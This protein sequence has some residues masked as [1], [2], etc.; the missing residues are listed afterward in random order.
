LS[1]GLR[2]DLFVQSV[3]CIDLDDLRAKGIAGLA[4]DL[5]NTLVPWNTAHLTQDVV[6]W[7]AGMHAAGVRGCIVSNAGGRRVLS[8]AD[9]LGVPVLTWAGKPRTTA[10][11]A[12]ARL[13]DLDPSRVAMVGDQ[14]FTDMYGARRAGM[15]TILVPPI[16]GRDFATTR[17][18]RL[19]E[20]FL[21]NRWKRLGLM[22]WWPEGGRSPCSR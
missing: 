4:F 21:L 7:F 18:L 19:L 12:A 11:L 17:L 20:R 5:D 10:F 1:W 3:T 16:S 8:V 22:T 15:F 2:P 9:R 6:D 14:V 13:L